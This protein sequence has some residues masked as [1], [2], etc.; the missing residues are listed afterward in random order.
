VH[1]K[2]SVMLSVALRLTWEG[3]SDVGYVVKPFDGTLRV[4]KPVR[5][6]LATSR[7]E[8]CVVS[9]DRLRSVDSQCEACD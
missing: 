2:S 3:G 7:N 5:K 8:S 6:S 9:G 4:I 1:V